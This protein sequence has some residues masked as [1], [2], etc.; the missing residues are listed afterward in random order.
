MRDG[1][2]GTLVDPADPPGL[3]RAIAPYLRDP[4]LAKATGQAGRRFA[5][6]HLPPGELSLQL[7]RH[8]IG[9]P[10]RASDAPFHIP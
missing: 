4:E 2:T 9:P 5:R 10:D 8:L 3:A 7:F 1:L 6:A